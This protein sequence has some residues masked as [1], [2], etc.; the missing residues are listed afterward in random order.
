MQDCPRSHFLERHQV[1]AYERHSM[2]SSALR[3]QD[4]LKHSLGELCGIC[5]PDAYDTLRE[6]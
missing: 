5:C 3:V 4:V 1:H 2:T 6:G